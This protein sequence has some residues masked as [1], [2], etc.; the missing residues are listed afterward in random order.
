ML[1]GDDVFQKTI[2]DE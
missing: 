2:E 1:E